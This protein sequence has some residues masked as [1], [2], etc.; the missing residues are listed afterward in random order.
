M[1]K[2]VIL[3]L[4]AAFIITAG[5]T[6]IAQEKMHTK[7]IARDDIEK[8][9]K[10]ISEIEG[11]YITSVEVNYYD[12][13]TGEITK[14]NAPQTMNIKRVAEDKIGVTAQFIG[15]NAHDCSFSGENDPIEAVYEAPNKFVFREQMEDI[16]C[17]LVFQVDKDF[18]ITLHDEGGL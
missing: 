5:L 3:G 11:E 14:F 4:I 12:G 10:L 2:L 17:E 7:P 13:E 15:A 6:A 18:N 9:D 16:N 8:A 1:K